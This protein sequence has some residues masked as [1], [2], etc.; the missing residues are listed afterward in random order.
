MV[1]VSTRKIQGHHCYYYY[2]KNTLFLL[3]GLQLLFQ[4]GELAKE[5]NK[6]GGNSR[7]SSSM[8]LRTEEVLEVVMFKEIEWLFEL[9][10]IIKLHKEKDNLNYT[11]L[12]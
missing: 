3:K 5:V 6:R 4:F 7:L 1:L 10:I 2:L 12:I 8:A 11:E 9:I